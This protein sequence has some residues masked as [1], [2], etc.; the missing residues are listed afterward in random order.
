MIK[1]IF[2]K[3]YIP[4]IRKFAF[5]FFDVK[6]DSLDIEDHITRNIKTENSLVPN[7]TYN[8]SMSFTHP[9]W[10][11]KESSLEPFY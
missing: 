9:W 3:L 5:E 11:H 7:P 4:L 8:L 1:G 2:D 10:N 6:K